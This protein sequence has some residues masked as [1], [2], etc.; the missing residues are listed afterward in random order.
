MST[1]LVTGGGRGIGR[2]IAAELTRAG[3]SVAVTGRTAQS[4]DDAVRS[5]D[6]ALGLAGDATDRGAVEH[7]VLRAEAELGPL[8]LI[9]ANAGRFASAGPIW[10]DDPDEWWR[11]TEVNLRGP[12]LALWAGLRAM[13]PRRRGRIV[14]LGSG[15]GTAGMP[16]ASAYSVSKTG[17]MR[18]VESVAGE[19]EGTGIAV[20]VISPGMVATEMTQF[21][22]PFLAHYPDW[23]DMAATEGVPPE[24]AAEL[25]LELASGR[26][27]ALS[28]RFI[29]L[30]TDLAAS[31]A[32]G[33]D[34]G[35]LRLIA[36]P[37][38]D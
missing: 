15:I 18:L 33:E 17:V 24:R 8:D 31:A 37:T 20:F 6:A 4:L 5:G 35:T 10:V 11:D 13:V 25:V 3:W 36:L 1:A 26:H 29:R 7:A 23:R 9:V 34:S 12:Q 27:D 19:L 2:T 16:F 21:P 22:E 14:V 28:G 38:T 32:A 30:T